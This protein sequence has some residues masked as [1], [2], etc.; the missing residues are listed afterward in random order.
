MALRPPRPFAP[1]SLPRSRVHRAP[2]AGRRR[3]RSC[4]SATIR[5]RTSTS[6]TR[7][8]RAARPGLHVAVHRLPAT[9]TLDELLAAGRARST[10]TPRATAS[11]CS[12]RSRRRWGRTPSSRSST[13]SI[14]PRTSTA[15]IRTTSGCSS[16]AVPA[17]APCTPS[18]VIELLDARAVPIAGRHAVVDRPQRDRRQADGAAAAQRD[19]TVT[20]CHSRTADL[21]AV[22]RQA[23]IL[24]SAI[25]RPG[26]RHAVDG[27]ARRGR[28]RCRARRRSATGHGSSSCSATAVRGSPRSTRKGSTVVGDVHP[29]VADVAGA[30]SPVPGGVGPLTIAMLLKNTLTA[31]RRAR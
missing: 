2:P 11:S 28:G 17:L 1:S 27:Q 3:C 7:S 19:A 6:A 23:D 8:A 15:S 25:G 24:V 22:T 20:I 29:A 10:P 12:R 30:L 9:T 16:R 26:L 4:W 13:R 31:A 18:G 21:P 14:R 5:R